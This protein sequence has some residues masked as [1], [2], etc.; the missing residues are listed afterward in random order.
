MLA[1]VNRAIQT[2]LEQ[3][4][5]R[6]LQDFL[7]VETGYDNT[8]ICN[9]GSLMTVLAI[10]GLRDIVGESDISDIALSLQAKLATLLGQPGHALQMWFMRDPDLSEALVQSLVVPTRRVAGLIGLD[11]RDVFEERE[12]ILPEFVVFETVAMAFW[13]RPSAL[14]PRDQEQFKTEFKA[15]WG[16]FPSLQRTQNIISLIEPLVSKHDAAVTNLVSALKE[17]GVRVSVLDV[18]DALVLMRGSLLPTAFISQWTPWLPGSDESEGRR[19]SGMGQVPFRRL[20]EDRL[21]LIAAGLWPRLEEQLLPFDAEVISRSMVRIGPFAMGGVDMTMGPQDLAPFRR[22]LARTMDIGRPPWRVSFLLEANPLGG[23]TD[24]KAFLAAVTRF[25]NNENFYVREALKAMKEHVQQGGTAV[26]LRISFATWGPAERLQLVEERIDRLQRAVEAWGQCVASSVCGDP[27]DGVMSSTLGFAPRST[28]VPGIAPLEDALFMLPW[29]RDSS[30]YGNGSV[31]FRTKDGRIW[32]YQPGSSQEDTSIDIVY[33]P[34]GKGKS[35]WL[36]TVN[37]GFCLSGSAVGAGGAQLPRLAIIDIGPSSSGL[38]SLLREALPE[39]RKHEVIYKRLRLTP[40]CAIN[41]F[42]TQL[43]CRKPLFLERSF[44][45][46]FLCLLATE[47]GETKPPSGMAQLAGALVDEVYDI[48]SDMSRSG[49]PKIYTFGEAPEVDEILDRYKIPFSVVEDKPW[50]SIVDMLFERGLYHE[51]SLAQRYAVP[52]LEDLPALAASSKIVD[53]FGKTPTESGE[54]LLSF[55][56]RTAAAALR[57]YPVLAYPT[58]LDIGEG[59]R[60]VSL[61]LNDVAPRGGGPAAKQTALMYMLARFVLARDFYLNVEDVDSFPPRYRQFHTI[62]IQ[63]LRDTPK[64]LVMDEFHRTESVRMVR[65]QVITDMREG[66]KWNVQIALAS[67]LLD[68]FDSDMLSLTT[69]IWI[70]GVANRQDVDKTAEMFGLSPAARA[71]VNELSGPGRDGAPFL[72]VLSLRDGR[73]EHHLY[74][75]L[76]PIELWAFSTTPDDAA[77]RRRLTELLGPAEARRRLAK[78]FPG[79]SA[80]AWIERRQQALLR[81]GGGAEADEEALRNGVIDELVQKIL[82]GDIS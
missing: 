37:L 36:N 44:L 19:P 30:P 79:G 70:M 65:E 62:R 57:D 13:T 25:S 9:D 20:E 31:L 24:F 10:N 32:P 53:L 51:A 22:L 74:N 69:G 23:L 58:R 60:V 61:D 81:D 49:Q 14:S 80:K 34:P 52:R 55:F 39:D 8:F 35:V 75:K 29:D 5:A 43:G 78:A 73:H 40:D 42:D 18:R 38:I 27:L 28:A 17:A 47:P 72:A 26:K 67:Q 59:V 45:I 4:T 63:R 54:P 76:G 6:T 71:V 1:R 2:I 77:L 48:Y 33:A 3:L 7:Y 46:N 56:A 41:P 82:R 66:R 11:L 12:K 15:K 16:L 68:D 21:G 64:R 50:W